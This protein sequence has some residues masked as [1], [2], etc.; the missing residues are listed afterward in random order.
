MLKYNHD[1]YKRG[2]LQIDEREEYKETVQE[3]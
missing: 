1:E 2:R 3:Q